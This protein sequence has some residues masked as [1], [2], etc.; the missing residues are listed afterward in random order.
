MGAFSFGGVPAFLVF[1]G[2]ATYSLDLIHEQVSGL[3]LK[4]LIRTGLYA[5]LG[6]G[7]TYALVLLLTV[8]GGCLAYVLVERPLLR[9]LRGR[10]PAARR[11]AAQPPVSPP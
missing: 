5:L 6:S 2:N 3:L 11:P 1:I 7:V 8:A 10:H 9:L 4:V